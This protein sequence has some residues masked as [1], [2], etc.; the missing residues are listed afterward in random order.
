MSY[1]VLL[2]DALLWGSREAVCDQAGAFC[3]HAPDPFAHPEPK[4]DTGVQPHLVMARSRCPYMGQWHTPV[5]WS[6][7]APVVQVYVT[8]PVSYVLALALHVGTALP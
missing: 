5:S 1:Q 7:F 4:H 8:R 3:R 6:L 2:H